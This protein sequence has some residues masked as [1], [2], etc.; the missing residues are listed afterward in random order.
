[1][2]EINEQMTPNSVDTF[3]DFFSLSDTLMFVLFFHGK[4]EMVIIDIDFN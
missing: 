4:A 2:S 3:L 1:M